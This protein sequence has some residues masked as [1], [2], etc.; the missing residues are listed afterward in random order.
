MDYLH[1]HFSTCVYPTCIEMSRFADFYSFFFLGELNL[2]FKDVNSNPRCAFLGGKWNKA[3][4][5]GF[6]DNSASRIP[7]IFSFTHLF[8]CIRE[9]ERERGK[10]PIPIQL[11]KLTKLQNYNINKA[12]NYESI[13]LERKKQVG[14]AVTSN[15]LAL[16]VNYT[17]P[18]KNAF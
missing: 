2:L 5:V 10:L 14:N 3:K 7:R 11:A 12:T 17:I 9:R 18:F 16:N 4:F 1:L 6:N 8:N 13:C 15:N